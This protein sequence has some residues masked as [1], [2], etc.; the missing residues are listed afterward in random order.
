MTLCSVA[1][2]VL[3]SV[4][5][6]PATRARAAGSTIPANVRFV[7]IASGLSQPLFVTHAGDG[8][9]RLFILER[10]GRIL[11]YEN[12]SL[13]TTPFLDISTLTNTG[14]SEQGLLGLAFA[15]DY[16]TSGRFYVVHIK[17][18]S[19]TIALVRYLVSASDPDRADPASRQELLTIP[20]SHTN[21]NGGMILFGPDGTLYMSVGDG[22][23][24]GDP[25][26]NGQNTNTLLGKILRLDVSGAGYSIPPTNPFAGQAQKR[27]EIWSYG[28]RNPWRISFDRLT[29]DLYIGDVGQNTQEEIDFQP[30][31]SAGGKNYG[32]NILEGNLCYLSSPCTPPAGY[33]APVSVYNHGTNDSIGCSVTGGYVYRGA[34][35]PALAGVYLYADFCTGRLWGLRRDSSNHWVRALIRDTDYMISSFGEGEHGELFITDY[36]SGRV[37]HLV[38]API[39]TASFASQASRD[40]MIVEKS[41]NS[42]TGGSAN[43]TAAYIRLGDDAQNRQIVGI[44]SFDTRALPD[45]AVVLSSVLSFRRSAITGTPLAAL[46]PLQADIRRS[47]FGSVP[48]LEPADF[49]APASRSR[50]AG[51]LGALA[52]G[53]YRLPLPYASAW[54]NQRGLTQLRLY[55]SMP[56]NNDLGADNLSIY[57]GDSPVPGDRPSLTIRYYV[58]E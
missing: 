32:W 4:A 1:A 13:K 11:I 28:L 26:G 37:L 54:V 8:S 22:G 16:K 41:E 21:H 39:R 53:Y 6:S 9:N 25:D 2:L 12:G 5:L 40:G 3:L 44:L 42:S 56:D 10:T 17:A 45:K 29:G 36:A 38:Q 50:V 35:F 47:Y 52:D 43:S 27:G 30:R 24:T 51:T 34:N 31:A 19:N 46:S 57:S 55:F 18:G 33:A 20:K 15:P 49:Q 48:A 14:G 23:G 58:T 7:T